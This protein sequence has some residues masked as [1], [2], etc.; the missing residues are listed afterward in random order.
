MRYKAKSFIREA[1]SKI[2]RAALATL[3]LIFRLDKQTSTDIFELHVLFGEV[4]VEVKQLLIGEFL[5]EIPVL[6]GSHQ[7]PI[8]PGRQ[9]AT[10]HLNQIRILNYN[11]LSY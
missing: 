3:T 8:R 11:Y 10:A 7:V 9:V 6:A 4:V 5:F 2:A 1:L